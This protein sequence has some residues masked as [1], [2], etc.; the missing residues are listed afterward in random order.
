[1]KCLNSF[2]LIMMLCLFACNASKNDAAKSATTDK[3]ALKSSSENQ[4]AIS[5]Q[6]AE[7]TKSTAAI[8]KETAKSSGAQ[9]SP[10]TT[11]LEMLDDRQNQVLKQIELRKTAEAQTS[12]DQ[13]LARNKTASNYFLQARLHIE[14]RNGKEAVAAMEKA[15]KL[16]PKNATILAAYAWALMA[17]YKYEEAIRQANLAYITDKE[18]DLANAVKGYYFLGNNNFQEAIYNFDKA[19]ALNPNVGHYY[20]GRSRAYNAKQQKDKACEDMRSAKAKGYGL[21]QVQLDSY[22]ATPEPREPEDKSNKK[23]Y[24]VPFGP[25]KN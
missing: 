9:K 25:K 2:V 13:L 20:Y 11:S 17:N 10:R 3:T 22:C 14:N 18:N 24:K 23:P 6:N 21:T 19:I 1:M 8:N 4:A 15:M 16:E 7:K 5:A 12:I